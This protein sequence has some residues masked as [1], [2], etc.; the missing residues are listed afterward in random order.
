MTQDHQMPSAQGHVF[1]WVGRDNLTAEGQCSVQIFSESERSGRANAFF[2]KAALGGLLAIIVPPHVIYPVI[3]V[4]VGFI[5]RL[6]IKK[7]KYLFLA[8]EVT[9]PKCGS[10]QKLPKSSQQFPFIYFCSAC[11]SRAEIQCAD[12][13]EN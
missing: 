7:Q 12:F 6:S 10:E 8:G 13:P 9:C 2:L 1:Q 11:S 3:G 5:G 4:V